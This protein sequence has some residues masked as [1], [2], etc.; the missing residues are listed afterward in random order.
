MID[1]LAEIAFFVINRVLYIG[2]LLLFVCS[3]VLRLFW[4]IFHQN[5]SLSSQ[6]ESAAPVVEAVNHPNIAPQE[7]SAMNDPIGE[8]LASFKPGQIRVVPLEDIGQLTLNI[9]QNEGK[10][11]RTLVISNNSLAKRLGFNSAKLDDLFSPDSVSEHDIATFMYEKTLED[12]QEYLNNALAGKPVEPVLKPKTEPTVTPAKTTEPTQP[13]P[14]TQPVVQEQ[15]HVAPVIVR[16][17]NRKNHN[18]TKW[19]GRYIGSGVALRGKVDP[20]EQFY[21]DIIDE[22]IDGPNRVWGTDLSRSIDDLKPKLNQL[23]Q[24]TLHGK[25]PVVLA[26]GEKSNRINYEITML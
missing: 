24:I 21:V 4:R 17:A 12:V 18:K 1:L 3:Y 6:K 8:M 2:A 20:Y 5:I 19:I 16:D 13:A 25:T 26:S 23:M 10:A 14:V 11:K 22:S 7:H 15:V 9:Y